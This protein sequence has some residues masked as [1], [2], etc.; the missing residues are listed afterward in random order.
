MQLFQMTNYG[1]TVYVFE[2]TDCENAQDSFEK[3][4]NHLSLTISKGEG[5]EPLMNVVCTYENNKWYVFVLPRKAFRP[6]QYS[7]EGDEQ[8]LVS[9]ATVEM[10]GIFITPVE[11]H[12]LKITREDI[13]S[14]LQQVSF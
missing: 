11:S 3:L 1:R 9:P 10:C 4:Y 6:W 5:T 14:I 13:Q 2:S 8:L 7:A 12:F